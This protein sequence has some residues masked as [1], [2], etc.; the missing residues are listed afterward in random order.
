MKSVT[1]LQHNDTKGSPV[2][3]A[4]QTA[5]ALARA[6]KYC[7]KNQREIAEEIG[8]PKPNIISMMK[9]GDTKIPIERIPALAKA[10]LVDP[11]HMLKLAMEEYHPEIWNV[12][13]DAFG[14]PLTSNEEDMVGIYRIATINND[15][16]I[17]YD[18]FAVVLASLAMDI[19]EPDEPEAW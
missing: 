13:V 6:I 3:T 11:V 4:S 12:L 14:E 1:R 5:N 19:G 10:C 16:E 9:K 8:F 18:R 17:T 2:T 7:G 15:I